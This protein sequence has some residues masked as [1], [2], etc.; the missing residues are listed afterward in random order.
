MRMGPGTLYGSIDRMIEAGP[1]ARGDT[2]NPRRIYYRLTAL[3]Q[4]SLGRYVIGVFV[5]WMLLFALGWFLRGSTPGYPVLQVLAG[6]LLGTLSMY[7][8]TRFYGKPPSSSHAQ[9]IYIYG[10]LRSMERT[11][12]GDC[13]VASLLAMTAR[14][15]FRIFKSL[16][17]SGMH[18]AEAIFLIARA[19]EQRRG[20]ACAAWRSYFP[21]LRGHLHG[22]AIAA[23]QGVPVVPFQI[24]CVDTI[25]VAGR[26]I[27]DL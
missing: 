16:H 17:I 26:L 10:P 12:D 6:F 24:R 20:G 21:L 1:V 27:G 19:C 2:Q 7:I 22:T 8:T 18:L 5:A 14:S 9:G 15:M 13:F 4:T 25:V 3:G 11:Y 23:D